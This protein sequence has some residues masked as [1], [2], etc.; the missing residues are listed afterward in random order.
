MTGFFVL[1]GSKGS[2]I[3]NIILGAVIYCIL[4]PQFL[5]TFTNGN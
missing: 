1:S 5:K 4:R 3:P 2:I